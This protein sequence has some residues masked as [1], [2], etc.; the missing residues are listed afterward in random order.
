MWAMQ[1]TPLG[2]LEKK[3]KEEG[4]VMFA[5]VGEGKVMFAIVGVWL[6]ELEDNRR[7]RL[8]LLWREGRRS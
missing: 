7:E 3:K 5:I 1:Q 6:S 8:R 4:K 2:Y